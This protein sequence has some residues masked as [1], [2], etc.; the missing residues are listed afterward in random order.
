MP[1]GRSFMRDEIK[2]WL[3][4][5]EKFAEEIEG[6]FGE[7]SYSFEQYRKDIK[8]KRAVERNLGVIGEAMNRILQIEED[9]PISSARKIVDTRNRLIHGYNKISDEIIWDILQ[10]DIPVLKQEVTR[11]LQG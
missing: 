8:T 2:T 10:N 5:I 11:L 9:L 1:T 7:E 3:Y 6:F 4:D